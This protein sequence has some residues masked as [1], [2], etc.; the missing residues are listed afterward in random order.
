M[1]YFEL[2]DLDKYITSELTESDAKVIGRQLLEGLQILHGDGLAHRDLKPANIFV[3]RH[4]PDWWVK[5]GDFGIIRHICTKQNS[6]LSRIGTLDYMAPEILMGNNDEDEAL[7]YTLAVDVWSLGCVLFR[8]LTQRLPFPLEKDLRLY[9]RQK[10]PFPTDVLIQHNVSKG[11]ALFV[12]EMMKSNPADRITVNDALLHSWASIQ[13]SELTPGYHE[14]YEKESEVRPTNMPR[15]SGKGECLPDGSSTGLSSTKPNTSSTS[16]SEITTN[17]LATQPTA[18]FE[19]TTLH[20]AVL[21]GSAKVAAFLLKGGADPNARYIIEDIDT[22]TPLHL[23]CMDGKESFVDLLLDNG[24]NVDAQSDMGWTA[25]SLAV[26]RT[27]KAIVRKLLDHSASVKLASNLNESPLMLAALVG[28]VEVLRMLLDV[29]ADP[30][31]KQMPGELTALHFAAKHHK[32]SVVEELLRRF[33]GSG[34]MDAESSD[35]HRPLHFAALEG[36]LD[37]VVMLLDAGADPNVVDIS[38]VTPLR[39]A[40]Q[41]GHTNVVKSLIDGG[42]RMDLIAEDGLSLIDVAMMAIDNEDMVTYL[43]LISS[44]A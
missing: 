32:T 21:L 42:A 10:N 23:A 24:A 15:I 9:L 40:I 6:T 34:I 44:S 20:R 2:G 19:M 11:G 13:E 4:A 5:L 22:Y 29:D 17:V 14:S 35:G 36:F 39:A 33:P 31:T 26:K 43:L 3:A 25:L 41:M 30:S 12:S 27:E 1:E 16:E 37:I 38:S 28:D 8:L 7:S 18:S